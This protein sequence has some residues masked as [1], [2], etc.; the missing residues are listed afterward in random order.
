MYQLSL[1]FRM[2]VMFPRPF[3]EFIH[4]FGLLLVFLI[5]A[6]PG[7]SHLQPVL[8]FVLLHLLLVDDIPV[9]G[10]V[11]DDGREDL[12]PPR[13]CL[14]SVIELVRPRVG[15]VI[16]R[17]GR[18]VVD[19][20]LLAPFPDLF[21]L[22]FLVFLGVI[23]HDDHGHLLL[24]RVGHWYRGVHG[25]EL[26]EGRPAHSLA[27]TRHHL[28]CNPVVRVGELADGFRYDL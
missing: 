22:N 20:P 21:L 17:P 26:G 10:D 3:I 11:G 23:R 1:M 16:V 4:L 28:L 12:P 5:V 19:L 14:H 2:M 18:I 7:P 15:V 24:H 25:P 8:G 27:H 6:V 13:F 9:L